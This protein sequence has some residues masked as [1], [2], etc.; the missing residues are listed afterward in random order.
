MSNRVFANVL[1]F[2][3]ALGCLSAA[4]WCRGYAEQSG[5][6][7]VADKPLHGAVSEENENTPPELKQVKIRLWTGKP[8]LIMHSGSG[9]L[10]IEE[11]TQL[12]IKGKTE[13]VINGDGEIIFEYPGKEDRIDVTGDGARIEF[14]N[15]P[16]VKVS[17]AKSVDAR[18]GASIIVSRCK[19]A[20]ARE[21]SSIVASDCD[22]VMVREDSKGSLTNCRSA[23]FREQS[24]G[25]ASNCQSLSVRESTV[26]C[27]NCP[28]LAVRGQS[29][30]SAQHCDK[31]E[32]REGADVTV[33]GVQ[34]I[35]V[36]DDATVKY[37]G[38]P[39]IQIYGTGVARRI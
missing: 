21:K 4:L 13:F 34:S 3:V 29:K 22:Q 27:E 26:E 17:S 1:I 14:A 23:E 33:R 25:S 31:V 15:G 18:N 12:G 16:D 2:A 8:K 30:V 19:N 32:A 6:L 10:T 20:T 9:D 37:S 11:S 28:T 36:R 35:Q 39:Q 5:P 7:L 38:S 24:S